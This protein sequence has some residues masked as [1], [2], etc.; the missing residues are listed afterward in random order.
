MRKDNLN[1]FLSGG[2]TTPAYDSGYQAILDKATALGYTLPSDG[3]KTKQNTLYVALKNAGFLAI[4]D[5]VRV[6]A[7]EQQ[8]F[9]LINW[10]GPNSFL[11]TVTGHAPAFTSNVGFTAG[12]TAPTTYVDENYDPSVNAINL[13]IAD[14]SF[15]YY[16]NG[17]QSLST[18]SGHI[19]NADDNIRLQPHR[20]INLAYYKLNG[21]AML[22]SVQSDDAS[23]LWHVDLKNVDSPTSFNA[24]KDGTLVVS[25]NGT[26][27]ALGVGNI[28]SAYYGNDKDSFFFIGA[29]SKAIRASVV[30][31]LN[32]YLA[33]PS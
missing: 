20:S 33:S 12:G 32:T 30:S 18:S 31:A 29:S 13:Q 27:S 24:Y 11:A 1:F 15:G 26:G 25:T 23:Y 5:I 14:G 17:S 10:A 9:S 2:P 28:R 3:Q 7:C 19:Q 8:N 16:K 22:G 6:Y 21:A 4:M